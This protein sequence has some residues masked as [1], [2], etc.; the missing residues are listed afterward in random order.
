MVCTR[1]ADQFLDKLQHASPKPMKLVINDNRQTLL[2]VKWDP[3]ATK[4]SM[5]RMFLEAP[6]NVMDAL[7]CY[8]KREHKSVAVEIKEFIESNFARYDYSHLVDPK[9]LCVV[10]SV[11]NL[12]AIYDKLNV[13]YF[14]NRLDVRITWFGNSLVKN[15]A[16]CT[17]GLYYDSLRL[18]KIHKCLDRIEVPEY[19]IEFVIFHEM[20]HGVC[21]SY[22][23]SKGVHRSHGSN[24][25]A[26]EKSFWAYKEAEEWIKQN[27]V[28]FFETR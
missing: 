17:L 13:R 8:I 24:F 11:F 5:H 26:L 18:I 9:K 1:A 6:Q 14:S 21:P 25:K 23:D 15:R 20:I 7:A 2:S 12:K 4:I 19:V 28:D 3:E 16:R 27:Q 22:I 10:G